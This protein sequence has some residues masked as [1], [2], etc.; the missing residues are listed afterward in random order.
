MILSNIQTNKCFN[1]HHHV[2]KTLGTYDQ[3]SWRSWVLSLALDWLWLFC[4]AFSLQLLPSPLSWFPELML[5]S[6]L[7]LGKRSKVN[8]HFILRPDSFWQVCRPIGFFSAT[9]ALLQGTTSWSGWRAIC[10]LGK[11]SYWICY[12]CIELL[13]LVLHLTVRFIRHLLLC[14]SLYICYRILHA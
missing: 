13:L 10:S 2:M 4:P 7:P 14:S 1:G 5:H 6:S 3:K 8:L 12:I 11:S 9:F